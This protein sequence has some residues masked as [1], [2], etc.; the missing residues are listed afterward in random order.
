[1]ARL[2]LPLQLANVV[3]GVYSIYVGGSGLAEAGCPSLPLALL[4]LGICLL[5]VN[6]GLLLAECCNSVRI[7]NVFVGRL[8]AGATLCATFCMFVVVQVFFFQSFT[9]YDMGIIFTD[10]TETSAGTPAYN[11]SGLVENG[12]FAIIVFLY[13]NLLYSCCLVPFVSFA[14]PDQSDADLDANPEGSVLFG[15]AVLA[16]VARDST[17]AV[18]VAPQAKSKSGS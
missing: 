4:L 10:P 17:V 13:I 2:L 3:F 1:M 8:Q 14:L 5:P 18:L 15:G 12:A 6:A 16:P 11:C 7:A 9:S